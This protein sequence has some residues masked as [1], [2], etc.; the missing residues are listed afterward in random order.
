MSA[1]R[2]TSMSNA[3]FAGFLRLLLTPLNETPPQSRELRAYLE[4]LNE[5]APGLAR[6]RR[7]ATAPEWCPGEREAI[8]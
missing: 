3:A 5:V 4:Y 2:L 8:H 1:S 7:S 6:S